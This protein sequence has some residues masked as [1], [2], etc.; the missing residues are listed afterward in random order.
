MKNSIVKCLWACFLTLIGSIL[1]GQED[2]RLQLHVGF[3]NELKEVLVKDSIFFINLTNKQKDYYCTDEEGKITALI[4]RGPE[5][6]YGLLKWGN[7]KV[8]GN[9]AVPAEYEDAEAN[10]NIELFYPKRFILRFISYKPEDVEVPQQNMDKLKEVAGFISKHPK[11]K[12]QISGHCCNTFEIAQR[13]K[14]AEERA[15]NVYSALI[16]LGISPNQLVWKGYGDMDAAF[17]TNTPEGK[18]ANNRVE[19]RITDWK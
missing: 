1:Y 2:T 19:L 11:S 8:L 18:L 10:M 7:E 6:D 9:L 17:P 14:I 12:F 5:Y 16:N 15:K 13:N 3:T 4:A